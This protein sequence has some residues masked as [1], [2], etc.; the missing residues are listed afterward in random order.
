VESCGVRG[1]KAVV[2]EDVVEG[3]AGG[4]W[5]RRLVMSGSRSASR[6]GGG[7]EGGGRAGGE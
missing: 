1:S 3:Q 6:S 4:G 7:V 2:V 5:M